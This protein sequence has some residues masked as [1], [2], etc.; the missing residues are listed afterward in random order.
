M[1]F[2]PTRRLAATPHLRDIFL[3]YASVYLPLRA[4]CEVG[5]IA[6]VGKEHLVRNELRSC[7][8]ALLKS[9]FAFVPSLTSVGHTRPP[10]W[11]PPRSPIAQARKNTARWRHLFSLLSRFVLRQHRISPLVSRGSPG[12]RY[13]SDKLQWTP[14]AY[15]CDLWLNSL[16]VQLSSSRRD[17]VETSCG[18]C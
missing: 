18:I 16:K 15:A 8:S 2:A 17:F 5:A 3:G 10:P 6:R 11:F 9:P 12:S 4:R 7:Y 14:F 1:V 13:R